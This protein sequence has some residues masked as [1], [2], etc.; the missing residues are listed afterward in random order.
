MISPVSD[1]SN[2][3]YLFPLLLPVYAFD[4]LPDASRQALQEWPAEAS[5]SWP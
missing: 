4:H 5:G 1:S 3:M 2:V